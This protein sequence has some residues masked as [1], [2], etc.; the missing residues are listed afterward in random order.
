MLHNNAFTLTHIWGEIQKF[1]AAETCVWVRFNQ[2]YLK[3]VI[4]IVVI[5]NLIP[6]LDT[7]WKAWV[8]FIPCWQY[9]NIFGEKY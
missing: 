4:K 6:T 5:F 1:K 2:I 8:Y 9:D 3:S 7:F